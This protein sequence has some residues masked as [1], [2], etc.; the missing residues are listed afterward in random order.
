MVYMYFN[1]LSKECYIEL[2]SLEKKIKDV[3]ENDLKSYIQ[4]C[5][6]VIFVLKK[7]KYIMYML[8]NNVLK[9][10]YNSSK[11]LKNFSNE[12]FLKQCY[13]NYLSTDILYDRFLDLIILKKTNI[14]SFDK[15]TSEFNQLKTKFNTKECCVSLFTNNGVHFYTHYMFVLRLFLICFFFKKNFEEYSI[16]LVENLTNNYIQVLNNIL[17]TL[18]KN[19]VEDVA[20]IQ[21]L[22]AVIEK[23]RYNLVSIKNFKSL[24]SLY[25]NYEDIKLV[26]QKEF[27]FEFKL[28][29]FANKVFI[30]SNAI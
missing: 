11:Y 7:E 13:M 30:N 27:E 24:D 5:N 23:N 6:N 10:Y 12:R 20:K 1:F 22:E 19:K 28:Y 26:L 16:N 21:F 14:H 17:T 15:N 18:N 9:K 4:K 2:F 25:M 3:D 8:I 29:S